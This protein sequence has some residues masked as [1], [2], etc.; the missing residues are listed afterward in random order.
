MIYGYA[1]FDMRALRYELLAYSIG[2]YRD[3]NVEILSGVGR[4]SLSK[5]SG[6]YQS[7]CGQVERTPKL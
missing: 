7:G 4:G 3:D 2:P 5:G 6:H 1:T